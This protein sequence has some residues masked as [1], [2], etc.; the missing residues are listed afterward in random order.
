MYE[1][2]DQTFT[3]EEC[4]RLVKLSRTIPIDH[5][6][7]AYDTTP[8]DR[9]IAVYQPVLGDVFP[10]TWTNAMLVILLPGMMIP[11]HTDGQPEHWRRHVVL[12]TNDSVWVYHDGQFQQLDRGGVYQMDPM[13]PHGALNWGG[14][15]RIHLFVDVM[16]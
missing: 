14:D 1:R 10:G 3:A 13:K 2:L 5:S 8:P 16:R 12:Q 7:G 4:H 15:P 9:T 11:K 6:A